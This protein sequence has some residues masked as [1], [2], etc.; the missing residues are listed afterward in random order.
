[1]LRGPPSLATAATHPISPNAINAIVI[2]CILQFFLFH[3]P[4][5]CV[6]YDT[7]EFWYEA[8][9]TY[10]PPHKMPLKTRPTR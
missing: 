5:T 1:M 4:T 8:A 6:V 2:V 9:A 3:V 10:P 7:G